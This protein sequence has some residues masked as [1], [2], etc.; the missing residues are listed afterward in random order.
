[1]LSGPARAARR[2]RVHCAAVGS[3]RPD[4][5]PFDGRRPDTPVSERARASGSARLCAPPANLKV[6]A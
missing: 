5:Q 1:M 4:L 6:T 3:R 2:A